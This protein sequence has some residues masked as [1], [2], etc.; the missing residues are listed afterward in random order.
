MPWI[1]KELDPG[2]ERQIKEFSQKN[3]PGINALIDKYQNDKDIFVFKSR[4]QADDF[5]NQL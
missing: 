1:D 5:I 4:E 3:L 2:L